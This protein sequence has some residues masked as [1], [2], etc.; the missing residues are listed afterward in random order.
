VSKWITIADPDEHFAKFTK[1]RMPHQFNKLVFHWPYCS[2]CGL[3][4]LKNEA[5][6]KAARKK[7]EF[8]E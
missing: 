4:L 3:V 2:R 8:Y 7:C 1:K 6:R 5:T